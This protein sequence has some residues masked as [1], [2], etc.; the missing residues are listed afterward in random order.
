M[1]EYISLNSVVT[2]INNNH[3][4]IL[5][6]IS[7]VYPIDPTRKLKA[8]YDCLDASNLLHFM[9]VFRVSLI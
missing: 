1:I 2:K 7:L 9:D 6:D 5:C 3:Q 8:M 4:K